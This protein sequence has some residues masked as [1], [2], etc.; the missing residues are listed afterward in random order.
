MENAV[1]KALVAEKRRG[2]G[3]MV[4]IRAVDEQMH[5][6]ERLVP[7]SI[8][9][10]TY[11]QKCSERLVQTSMIRLYLSGISFAMEASTVKVTRSMPPSSCS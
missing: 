7:C 6:K 11:C 5:A 4:V 1:V 3:L 10:I 2:W 8:N 9:V